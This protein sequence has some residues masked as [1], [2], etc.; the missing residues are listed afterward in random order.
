MNHIDLLEHKSNRS[1]ETLENICMKRKCLLC[2]LL[3]KINPEI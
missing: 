3:F 2:E 1:I